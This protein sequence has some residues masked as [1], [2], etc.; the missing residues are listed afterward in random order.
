MA[1]PDIT[2]AYPLEP[3]LPRRIPSIKFV[4]QSGA[5]ERK[6]DS[7][8][9]VGSAPEAAIPVK[10]RTV[11]G[12]H[13]SLEPRS[14][15][16][17]VSDLGSR[18]G[19]YIG[20][21]K[22]ERARIPNGAKLRLGALEVNVTYASSETTPDV[23]PEGRFGSLYGRT[24]VM[25][26]LF[27]KIAQYAATTLPVLVLGETG[28]GKELVASAI[29]EHSPA[30]GGPFVVVDC[31]SLPSHLLE[32]E[33]F[34]HARGAFTGAEADHVG[35][36]ELADGGTLF[37][38]EVGEL[39]LDLQP[40]LLR[41]LETNTIRRVGE[42]HYRKIN[43]RFVSATHRDLRA[44][45]GQ[46]TFRDDLFF[47]LA[48]LTLAL[49]ALRDRRGDVPL[50][51]DA[52]LLP[53]TASELGDESLRLVVDHPWPGNVRELRNFAQRL[54]ALGFEHAKQALFDDTAVLSTPAATPASIEQPFKLYRE[55]W[56]E[57]GERAFAA[58]AL[59]QSGGN[60]A[61][62]ARLAGVDRT[63][64]FRLVRKYGIG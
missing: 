40:K 13:A 33:L 28:T 50:L 2:T 8:V 48:V 22:I 7:L 52:F 59:E 55:Q 38:D 16:L 56:I 14:D 24:A 15:G 37:L 10:D 34:G 43:V 61:A 51:L 12:A 6:I 42:T 45:V 32:S 60:I 57:Q 36:F 5:H 30:Q 46:R 47:R 21:L 63:Y 3:A 53:R 11:S 27:T 23:W 17:W 44:M 4:D 25:R 18:N 19:T 20:D 39:P 58:K 9:V 31:A 29:H 49:P 62:A 1:Q 41:V 64:F 54:Q 35:A 26:E